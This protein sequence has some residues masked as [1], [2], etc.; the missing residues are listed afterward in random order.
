MTSYPKME[1]SKIV[2]LTTG[3]PV[4]DK[5]KGPV[6]A[7]ECGADSVTFQLSAQVKNG[8]LLALEGTLHINGKKLSFQATGRVKSFT[9]DP[10]GAHR[11]E[12]S[13]QQMNK[14]IWKQFCDAIGERQDRA[15]KIFNA[16]R[17]DE[18]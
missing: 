18:I 3:L 11:F 7:V 13:F 2:N 4:L 9:P 10:G 6:E 15:D 17:G 14:S 1:V 16:M 5:D 12:I 8:Q